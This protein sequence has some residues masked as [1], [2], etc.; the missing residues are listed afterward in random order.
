MLK[1]PSKMLF[2]GAFK[3]LAV[4]GITEPEYNFALEYRLD[5]TKQS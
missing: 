2:S 5:L 1:C 4:A 3:H